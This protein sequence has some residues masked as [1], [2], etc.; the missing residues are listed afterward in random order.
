[1]TEINANYDEPWKEAIG[2]YFNHFL[3]FFF[4]EVYIPLLSNSESTIK[5]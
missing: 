5:K 4:P 3:D 1:M 2:D